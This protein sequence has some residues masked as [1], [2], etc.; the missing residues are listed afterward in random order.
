MSH[1]HSGDMEMSDMDDEE[2]PV[3]ASTTAEAKSGSLFTS[4]I[5]VAQGF[6]LA[7]AIRNT[8]ESCSHCMMHPQ[9]AT[10]APSTPMVLNNYGLDGHVAV[11][12]EI[13]WAPI[14]SPL[15]FV[16][17]HDHD[18]PGLNGSRYILNSSFRI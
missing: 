10:N 15:T 12:P 8:P 17:V 13:V 6:D 7:D 4:D 1:E 2:M 5:E 18:P 11:A 3:D 14:A 16:D 9:S